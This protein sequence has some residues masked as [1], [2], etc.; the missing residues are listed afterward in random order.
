MTKPPTIGAAMRFITSAPGPLLQSKG[1][2]PIIN[3]LRERW[4]EAAPDQGLLTETHLCLRDRASSSAAPTHDADFLLDT[5]PAST[6][7]ESRT[8]PHAWE[9]L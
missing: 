6:I 9:G 2:S 7:L 4:R 5:R 1:A 8:A 3:R